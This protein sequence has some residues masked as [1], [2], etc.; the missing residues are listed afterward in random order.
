MSLC[1]LTRHVTAKYMNR[2]EQKRTD[3]YFDI[4]KYLVINYRT[5]NSCIYM[6]TYIARYESYDYVLCVCI[7]IH[8]YTHHMIHINQSISQTIDYMELQLARLFIKANIHNTIQVYMLFTYL[9]CHLYKKIDFIFE[10][11]ISVYILIT[12]SSMINDT[13]DWIQYH[14]VNSVCNMNVD[15][16][17]TIVHM[18]CKS[19]TEHIHH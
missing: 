12:G 3:V 1:Q 8:I 15:K 11:K 18:C 13:F 17:S 10:F 19:I 14:G 9:F 16:T 5:I 2:T 4:C 7:Y 6:H